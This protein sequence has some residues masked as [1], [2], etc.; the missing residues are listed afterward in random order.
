MAITI[1]VTVDEERQRQ[2]GADEQTRA[3]LMD[4]VAALR[5]DGRLS[6]QSRSYWLPVHDL[7]VRPA[8]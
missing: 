8:A 3:Q 6:L 7:K 5:D 4:L 1:T 2:S